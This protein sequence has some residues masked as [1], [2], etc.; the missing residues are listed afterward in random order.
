VLAL[1]VVN[2]GGQVKIIDQSARVPSARPRAADATGHADN[3][4]N[5]NGADRP[6]D[7]PRRGHAQHGRAADRPGRAADR[8]GRAGEDNPAGGDRLGRADHSIDPDALYLTAS[9]LEEA[10]PAAAMAAYAQCLAS[11]PEHYEARLNYGR[12]LHMAG[13]LKEAERIYRD[14]RR[15][16]ATLLFNLAVLLEDM[17]RRPEAINTYRE[18]LDLDP[19]FAD[20]HFNLARLF[21]RDHNRRE[22]L[23]HLLAYRR[24]TR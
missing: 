23:R 17:E 14:A 4:D 1:S 19:T 18:A 24:L 10:N 15:Y 11:D 8:P 6:G 20:A 12:L 5:A 9:A 7:S 3:T 22:T 16:D 2:E 13:R 21:E